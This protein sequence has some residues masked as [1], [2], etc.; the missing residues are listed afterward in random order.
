MF[1]RKALYSLNKLTPDTIVYMD[2]E[3]NAV[4]LFWVGILF[5]RGLNPVAAIQRSSNNQFA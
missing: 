3:K 4:R 5:R 2:A 1:D